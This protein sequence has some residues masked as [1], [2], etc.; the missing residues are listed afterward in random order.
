[1]SDFPVLKKPEIFITATLNDYPTI[2]WEGLAKMKELD[3]TIVPAPFDF[4]PDLL[5]MFSD[6]S[7]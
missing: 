6:E 4:S 2:K 7:K 5:Y 1:L 3:G